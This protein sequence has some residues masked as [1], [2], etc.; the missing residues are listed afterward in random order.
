MTMTTSYAW[1]CDACGKV[2][3]ATNVTP[4]GWQS[5]HRSSEPEH[6]CSRECARAILLA[7]LNTTLDYWFPKPTTEAVQR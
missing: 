3:P 6:A 7:E 1:T 2:A 5:I 4:A